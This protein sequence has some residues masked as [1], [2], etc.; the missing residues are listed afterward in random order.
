MQPKLIQ[1]LYEKRQKKGGNNTQPSCIG[2]LCTIN[3]YH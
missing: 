1:K 3:P 2:T